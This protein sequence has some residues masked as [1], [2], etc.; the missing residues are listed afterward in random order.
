MLDHISLQCDDVTA[1]RQF[2]EQLLRPMQIS[3][4]MERGDVVGFAGPDGFPRFWLGPSQGGTQR[5]VHLAFTAP[6]RSAVDAVH[7]AA[8]ELGT[9]ILHE[10]RIWPEY[11]DT[12]YG[13]FVRDLDGNN[14]EAVCH[15]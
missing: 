8:V 6:D 10:P 5:E 12:Y 13:V 9:E 11:H 3:V 7:Q 2:F 1:S 4:L 15:R 14:I